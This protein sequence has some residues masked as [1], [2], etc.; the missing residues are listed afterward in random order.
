MTLFHLY[1]QCHLV[2]ERKR[3]IGVPINVHLDYKIDHDGTL[4]RTEQ[5]YEHLKQKSVKT[6]TIF[7]S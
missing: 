6:S 1:T 4:L 2:Q 5:Q 3:W 7:H